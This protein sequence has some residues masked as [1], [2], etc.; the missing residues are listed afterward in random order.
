MRAHSDH[1]IRN[2]G[3]SSYSCRYRS[4]AQVHVHIKGHDWENV[5]SVCLTVARLVP[6]TLDWVILDL[7]IW[8]FHSR[9]YT[10]GPQITVLAR[11]GLKTRRG[12]LLL[13]TV[14][15][16][17]FLSRDAFLH[18][19]IAKSAYSSF[20][21]LLFISLLS[22]WTSLAFS[23]CPLLLTARWTAPPQ[24]PLLCVKMPRKRKFLKYSVYPIWHQQSR[25]G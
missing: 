14:R 11:Q 9:I 17:C 25:H 2:T 1:F 13:C 23:L 3:L 6:G 10:K 15:L 16:K 20:C 21:K 24:T 18:T 22:F 19:T 4:R 7:L 5:I 8:H 12:L